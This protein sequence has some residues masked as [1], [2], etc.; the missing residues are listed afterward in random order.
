MQRMS[1]KGNEKSY[2]YWWTAATSAK[3]CLPQLMWAYTSKSADS[4]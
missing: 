2:S 3:S 4:S 1:F